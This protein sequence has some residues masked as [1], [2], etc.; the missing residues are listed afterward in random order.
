LQIDVDEL[1]GIHIK[2]LKALLDFKNWFMGRLKQLDKACLSRYLHN[3]NECD[4]LCCVV[5]DLV[6][7]EGIQ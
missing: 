1:E 3:S 2:E 4:A 5:K 6:E 7:A